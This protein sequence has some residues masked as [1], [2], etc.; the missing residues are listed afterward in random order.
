M[1]HRV[2]R[3]V[4]WV[5]PRAYEKYFTAQRQKEKDE[6][7]WNWCW[8]CCLHQRL[9]FFGNYTTLVFTQLFQ[10]QLVTIKSEVLI[11]RLSH[12]SLRPPNDMLPQTITQVTHDDATDTKASPDSSP[13]ATCVQCEPAPVLSPCQRWS[14]SFRASS[15]LLVIADP[16]A[17]TH[18]CIYLYVKTLELC[19]DFWM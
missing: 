1:N 7:V 8:R 18:I 17:A 12:A 13:P 3:H 2:F 19:I 4:G 9:L 5:S 10:L 14:I 6:W 15:L 16:L 11:K